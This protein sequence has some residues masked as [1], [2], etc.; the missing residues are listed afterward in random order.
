MSFCRGKNIKLTDRSAEFHNIVFVIDRLH[1]KG[2]I[3]KCLNICNPAL[4]PELDGKNAVICEHC[5][6]WLGKYKY[7][8]KHMNY[9]RF[10]FF[11]FI[12]C[13]MWNEIKLSK[14]IDLNDCFKTYKHGVTYKRKYN[15]K[16]IISK[17]P[18]L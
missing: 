14:N 4:F 3:G 2:H 6:Y 16:N 7:M 17:K 13:S 10:P 8:T 5:N 12:I 9:N 1:I 11:L 18:H 15:E